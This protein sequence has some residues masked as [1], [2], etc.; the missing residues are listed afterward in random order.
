[1]WEERKGT[2]ECDKRTITY[3]IGTVQC[4]DGTDK[5]D[6]KVREPPNVILELHNVIIKPSI[7]RKK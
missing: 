7:V 5:Y 6:K 4:E 2:T 1:M 3:D